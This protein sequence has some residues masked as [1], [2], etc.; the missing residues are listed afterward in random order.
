[1]YQL[2]DYNCFMAL[3]TGLSSNCLD[4]MKQMI[5]AVD[6]EHQKRLMEMQ[7]CI[8]PGGG[9]KFLRAKM[10]E[11]EKKK[12]PEVLYSFIPYLGLLQQDITK[13]EESYD[14]KSPS[15][16]LDAVMNLA[17]PI[18]RFFYAMRLCKPLPCKCS[19]LSD[20]FALWKSIYHHQK[21][22]KVEIEDLFLSK[23]KKIEPPP[24]KKET[25][26]PA[27]P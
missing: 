25:D 6:K 5:A 24:P 23:S 26:S 2:D 14:F 8:N 18:E 16:N 17:I 15:V 1:M 19:D 10:E 9:F 12:K 22:E 3:I 11:A 20:H 7:P 4:R 21:A 13:I 27:P